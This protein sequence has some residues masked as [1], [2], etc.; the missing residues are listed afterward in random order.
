[1]ELEPGFLAI[2][3]PGHTAGHCC[4]LF[5]DQFLFTGDHLAWNRDDRCLEAYRDYCW[6]SWK[7]Q[8]ESMTRLLSFSFEWILP[9]HGQ[10]VRLPAD[11]Y[12][13]QLQL[14]MKEMGET[15]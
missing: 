14:L 11:E 4:L 5:N 1:M 9:G 10:R 12:H 2:P 15:N 8:T 3:T 7:R 13:R 6:H